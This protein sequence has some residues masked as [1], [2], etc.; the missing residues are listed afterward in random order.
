MNI[1]PD[2][3]KQYTA[4]VRYHGEFLPCKIICLSPTSAEI[5]YAN[6]VLVSPGQSIVVYDGDVCL[7]GGVVI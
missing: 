7:G 3:K 5:I 6:S 2:A 1:I 4:Q